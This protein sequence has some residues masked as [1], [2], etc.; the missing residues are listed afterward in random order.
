MAPGHGAALPHQTG[1][2]LLFLAG[3]RAVR[4][5]LR[6]PSPIANPSSPIADSSTA[7]Y[8]QSAGR[9]PHPCA[10]KATRDR[11]WAPCLPWDEGLGQPHSPCVVQGL[12]LL[13]QLPLQALHLY[14]QLNVLWSRKK[15]GRMPSCLPGHPSPT[16]HGN[17]GEVALGTPMPWQGFGCSCQS[18]ARVVF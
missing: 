13:L 3:T 12:L 8:R 14:L 1:A 15:A 11:A 5:A 6:V 2:C 9:H 10:H 4:G 17:E 7:C 16:A 18:V